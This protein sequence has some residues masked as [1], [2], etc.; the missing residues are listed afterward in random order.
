LPQR[1][2][3]FPMPGRARR[4]LRP[5]RLRRS[6]RLQLPRRR[7]RRLRIHRRAVRRF[8]NLQQRQPVSG[9]ADLPERRL[10]RRRAKALRAAMQSAD[11]AGRRE[12]RNDIAGG[13][14]V[15]V[16]PPPAVGCPHPRPLSRCGRRGEH[17]RCAD[18]GPRLPSPIAMG[19]GAGGEGTQSAADCSGRPCSLRASAPSKSWLILNRSLRPSQPCG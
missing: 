1:R 12:R 13:E 2:L 18:R 16:E 19:E 9:W 3:L 4:R 5:E 15:A 11:S 6:L 17:E 10:L 7:Q 8:A 14:P